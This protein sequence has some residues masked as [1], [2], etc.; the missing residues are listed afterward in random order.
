MLK[1]DFRFRRKQSFAVGCVASASNPYFTKAT[2]IANAAKMA[3]VP[4][5]APTK[6]TCDAHARHTLA[7]N[8]PKG[9]RATTRTIRCTGVDSE[10]AN[11]LPQLPHV[12]VPSVMQR[13]NAEV[14]RRPQGVAEAMG[15]VGVLWN[16]MLG[17]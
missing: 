7:G 1:A 10:F 6:F 14:Q 12:K 11:T 8:Q 15:W 17:W 3:K 9:T 16:A 5:S 2:T 13:Y 4:P